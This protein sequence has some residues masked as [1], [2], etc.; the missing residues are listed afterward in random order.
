MPDFDSIFRD[1]APKYD[2]LVSKEDYQK[3]LLPA[4]MK[5]TS[6]HRKKV[7]EFGAG[8]GRL[9]I[10]LAPIVES[11]LAFDSYVPMLK[12]AEEKLKALNLMN[13]ELKV[14]D[15]RH[16]PAESAVADIAISA[17][18]ICCLAAFG[19]Q[20]WQEAV[21]EGLSEMKRTTMSGGL[22]VIIETLGTGFSSPHPPDGLR[23]YYSH[24]ES[25]GF[26]ST[27]IRTDYLFRSKAE[28]LD[29]TTFFFGDDPIPA[30]AECPEGS[31]LPE[32]T[33]IWWIRSDSLLRA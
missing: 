15:H 2:V 23:E 27:W 28:A 1:Q 22:I 26:Q 3:N 33:G 5:I 7:V 21:D 19:G 14:A 20:S 8:T 13:Y 31:V 24:L 10:M 32:C 29:L 12:V 17:W 30:I 4:L 25:R 11:I 16:V 9:T 18:A 6:F